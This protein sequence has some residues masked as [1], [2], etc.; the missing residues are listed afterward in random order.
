MIKT[1]KVAH[2]ERS[3]QTSD[4]KQIVRIMP[5]SEVLKTYKYYVNNRGLEGGIDKKRA[6]EIASKIMGEGDRPSTEWLLKPITV[7]GVKKIVLDG[8]T[9]LAACQKVLKDEERDID[10]IVV[11]KY[12]CPK[13]TTLAEIISAYNNCQKPWST[14]T[15]VECYA[16]EGREDYV[17]LKLAAEEL[18][19]PFVKK[20]G[21]PNYR[22][23]CALLG[24]TMDT[25]LRKGTFK[26]ND[27][28]LERGKRV[29]ELFYVLTEGKVK[30]AAWF[31][32]FILAYVR[33]E[34]ACGKW[35]MNIFQKHKED[36]VFDGSTKTEDWAKQF[37]TIM[38]KEMDAA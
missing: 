17:L 34:A 25:E 27:E 10:L 36:F 38:E 12:N 29:K 30:T 31:E 1:Q 7:H 32:R 18:G 23:I 13:R 11:E 19:E 20:N 6:T 22:Y 3:L 21:K 15:Y 28:I 37:N 4:T 8:H 16:Q 33:M 2:D 26:Y 5:T 9:E 35:V 24:Q 14:A